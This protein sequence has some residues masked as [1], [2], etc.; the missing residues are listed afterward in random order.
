MYL[1]DSGVGIMTLMAI[2]S[3]SVPCVY[4]WLII[5]ES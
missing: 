1:V 5:D 4:A 2:N 3:Y